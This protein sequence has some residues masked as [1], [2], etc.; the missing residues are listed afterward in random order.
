MVAPDELILSTDVR[1][2]SMTGHRTT[3]AIRMTA[4][5]IH[6]RGARARPSRRR[7]LADGGAGALAPAPR[8]SM[9]SCTSRPSAVLLRGLLELAKDALRVTGDGRAEL[10]LDRVRQ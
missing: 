4:G 8:V 9:V 2:I 1:T 3:A 5:P 10:L 6:G 7:T